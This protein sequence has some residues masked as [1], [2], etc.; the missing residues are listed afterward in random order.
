MKESF[1][2][3][4]K[5]KRVPWGPIGY[6][7]YKLTYSRN[8]EWWQTC[9]RV[10]DALHDLGHDESELLYDTLFNL[11][12]FVSGRALWQLGT[13]TVQDIGA[14]S[15]QNCWAVCCNNLDNFC[16]IFNQLMLG[17]GVGVN[18]QS[19]YVYEL[20]K[21][22]Y[23][24]LVERVNSWDCDYVVPDNRE[25]WVELLKK[26]LESFFITGIRLQYC[27]NAIRPQGTPIKR[28][29]GIASGSE[30]LVK[31]MNQIIH[32]IRSR[33]NQKLQP[34]DCLDIVNIIGSI[35]RS[36]NVRRCSQIAL[37]DVHDVAFANAKNWK[38]QQIPDWRT[39]SNNSFVVNEASDIPNNLFEYPEPYGLCNIECARKYGRTRD[40]CN[41]RDLG[42]VGFNPCAEIALF[43]KE[44]CNLADIVLPN[45]ENMAVCKD[46]ARVLYKACK[47]ITS[48]KYSDP[49]TNNIVKENRR[50]GIGLTGF[51]ESPLSEIE[52]DELYKYLKDYDEEFSKQHGIPKSIKLTTIK[53]SGTLSLLA[54]C[55]PGMHVALGEYVF[56]TIRFAANS[57]LVEECRKRNYPIEPRITTEGNYDH[58]TMVV[59]FPMK[60]RKTLN[61]NSLELQKFLQRSWSDNAISITHYYQPEDIP[62]I[63]S[64]LKEN[65]NYIKGCSFLLEKGHG[66]PQAP[67]Q[68]VSR[69]KYE[70]LVSKVKPFD[71]KI[72][73]ASDTNNYLECDGDLCPVK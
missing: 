26:I 60:Y 63:K 29:G 5:T 39:S 35:V 50:I 68:P 51:V 33:L 22:H 3:Q 15:L 17:G 56:R 12:G 55:T 64:W 20:P 46:V 25:G 7:V 49:E 73:A 52:L 47:L 19:E 65:Y 30:P 2:Q 10:C 9:N 8:E 21:V 31:G 57:T 34:I 45:I 67:I 16:F 40:Y 1:L 59:T 14:D 28:F 72:K 23:T 32:I 37:G 6:I 54:G 70:D 41:W 11:R 27:T 69:E 36:G 62:R 4:Y 71:S 43:C 42:V 66:F 53:P 61:Y 24:P 58:S 48:L 18:I 38:Q 13:E 44:P